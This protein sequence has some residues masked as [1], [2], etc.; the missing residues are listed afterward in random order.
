MA[1]KRKIV[2]HGVNG[3]LWNT[4]QEL[5]EYT[6][7]V[8]GDEELRQQMSTSARIQVMKY[9]RD[10]YVQRFMQLMRCIEEVGTKKNIKKRNQ[11][12]TNNIY[13]AGALIENIVI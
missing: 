1:V 5:K 7:L 8:A 11:I 13:F 6:L 4:L 2:Q 3:F 9:G 10:R 12:G